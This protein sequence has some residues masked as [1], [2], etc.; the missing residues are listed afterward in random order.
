MGLLLWMFVF[1]LVNLSMGFA[2]AVYFGYGPPTLRDAWWALG[3]SPPRSRPAGVAVVEPENPRAE[4]TP[5]QLADMLDEGPLDHLRVEPLTEPYDDDVAELLSPSIPEAWDLNEKFVETSILKLNIAMMR[6]GARA[7]EID[8]RLRAAKGRL[9]AGTVQRCLDELMT[10]CEIYLT[11]QRDAAEQLHNRIGELGELAALGEEIE[12][13]NLDQAAQIETTLSNLR[14]MDFQSDLEAAGARLLTEIHRLRV[15]RHRLRDSQEVAFLTIA[16]YENRLDKIEPQLFNDTLT[17]LRNRIGLESL[18][19]EWWQ[20]GRHQS[21]SMCAALFDL[22]RFGSVNEQ[23]G[24]LVGDRILVQ[25]SQILKAT[26]AEADL[27]AR[28]AGQRF[29]LM[30]L[31]VG[32]RAATKTVELVRQSIARTTFRH[33]EAGIQL[34]ACAA[35]TEVTPADTPETVFQR[36]EQTLQQAKQSGPNRS[37][38]HNG[39]TAEPIEAPNLGAEFREIDV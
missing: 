2:L 20:Q 11:E 14:H 6:S 29:F 24:S 12:M 34:T 22:D 32:P 26:I 21:R 25:T 8:T 1:G 37:F 36:L 23:Y 16:R 19:Y 17:K 9:D 28:Y 3:D 5:S 33:G 13:A 27:A 39:R 10:D 18:L 31:D 35:L 30:T 7:T 4:L 38:F 15:A